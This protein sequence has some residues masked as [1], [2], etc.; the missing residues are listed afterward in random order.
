[1]SKKFDALRDKLLGLSSL[2]KVA[3]I[4]SE[5]EFLNF[6]PITTSVPELNIALSGNYNGGF[7]P[8]LT[9]FAADSKHFK[10][11][12]CLK[13]VSAYL[14]KYE[15]GICILLDSEF[16]ITKE[17]LISM[18]VDPS[19]VI[20]VP[21]MNIEEAKFALVEI[22]EELTPDDKVIVM[23][24][25]IGN[26]ASKKEVE[27]AKDK[28][29]VT[30]MTRAKAL[31]GF[32]RIVTPYLAKN[33]IPMLV[34]NHTYEEQ[35]MF[36][37]TIMGGGK[38]AMLSA[39]TVF[40]ISKS[41][42]KDE[43]TKEVSGFRFKL[44][45]E[46]SRFVREG[47]IIPVDIDFA[48]GIKPYQGIVDLAKKFNWLQMPKN[49]WYKFV[50]PHTGEV[51]SGDTNLR[52]SEISGNTEL[53]ESVLKA[54]LSKEIYEHYRIGGKI[55]FHEEDE[56]KLKL[57]EDIEMYEQLDDDDEDIDAQGPMSTRTV[58]EDDGSGS[59]YLKH[60]LEN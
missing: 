53:W 7:I 43:K 15:D 44:I 42:E 60:H 48:T 12:F 3:S 24:D 40:F 31:K 22:L 28:K 45:V 37:K 20:H 30:D 11:N 34:I 10:T 47:A 36:P 50:N 58:Y 56:R 5:S 33:K 25:S 16:G 41:K 39:N 6:E 9:I 59:P 23:F 21:V 19:R 2:T 35:G 13:M 52:M 32:F 17:Y 27:D 1:M 51:L 57:S 54:G 18:G 46:K 29:S 4:L 55:A 8:G 49:G 26:L 14:Q 38:G